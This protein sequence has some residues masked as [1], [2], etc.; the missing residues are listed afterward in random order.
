MTAVA[1]RHPKRVGRMKP[2][3][4]SH[5]RSYLASF[6]FF[7]LL[8]EGMYLV[9]IVGEDKWMIAW[10]AII[11]SVQC[12]HCHLLS[13]WFLAYEESSIIIIHS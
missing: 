8:L 6:F 11:A 10:G 2:A 1:D 9:L 7:I 3:L 4:A 5:L 12:H 13:S